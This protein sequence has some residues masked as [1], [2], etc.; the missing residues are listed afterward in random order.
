MI[1]VLYGLNL[2]LVAGWLATTLL[3]HLT[4]LA[5]AAHYQHVAQSAE[6]DRASCAR[7]HETLLRYI[8]REGLWQRMGMDSQ[9]WLGKGK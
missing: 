4:N 3:G 5:D 2:L 8:K 6:Y 9:P 1:R 7:K